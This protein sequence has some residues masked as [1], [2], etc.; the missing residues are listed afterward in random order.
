MVRIVIGEDALSDYSTAS[1]AA[2]LANDARLVLWLRAQLSNF[3]PNHEAPLGVE[4]PP[5]TWR[6]GLKQLNG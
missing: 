3:D 6:V 2:R 1:A 4:P 5:V